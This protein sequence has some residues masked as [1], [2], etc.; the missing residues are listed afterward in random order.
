V[1]AYRI[2]QV[3]FSLLGLVVGVFAASR[4][5]GGYWYAVLPL[6]V[7]V[8]GLR[9]EAAALGAFGIKEGK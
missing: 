6:I 2:R 4:L 7:V 1:S 3:V 5:V 8:F 9:L